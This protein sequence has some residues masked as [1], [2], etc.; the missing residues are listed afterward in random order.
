VAVVILIALATRGGSD[1]IE[2]V[3]RV[4]RHDDDIRRVG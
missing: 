3:D 1:R 4:E 2:R